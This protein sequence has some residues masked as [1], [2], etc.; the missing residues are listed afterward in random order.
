MLKGEPPTCVVPLFSPSVKIHPSVALLR[1]REFRSL[2]RAIQGSALKTRELLKKL[3]QNFLTG[4]AENL[5]FSALIGVLH[6]LLEQAAPRGA[7]RL[8]KQT[9]GLKS[10]CGGVG[11]LFSKSIP[12][13]SAT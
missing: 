6:F 2:R 11:V 5:K 7:S 4:F 10:F 8:A 1:A 13:K 3:D 9:K 12:T